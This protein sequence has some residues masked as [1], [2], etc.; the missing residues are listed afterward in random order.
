MSSSRTPKGLSATY[1]QT[2]TQSNHNFFSSSYRFISNLYP[3]LWVAAFIC[4]VGDLYK[5]WSRELDF[6]LHDLY[7]RS[8]ERGYSVV[9]TGPGWAWWPWPNQVI[10]VSGEATNLLQVADYGEP[11]FNS[12]KGVDPA[13]RKP[14]GDVIKHILGNKQSLFTMQGSAA[15]HERGLIK[16]HIGHD[17]LEKT[18]KYITDFFP[19]W[20]NLFKQREMTHSLQDE[21][22]YYTMQIIAR[23]AWGLGDIDIS[24]APIFRRMGD[25]IATGDASSPAF[26]KACQDVAALN[27]QHLLTHADDILSAKGYAFD[28][29][30]HEIRSAT[31]LTEKVIDE[32]VNTHAASGLVVADNLSRT[33]MFA[34]AIISEHDGWIARLNDELTKNPD[35]ANDW[36]ALNKAKWLHRLYLETLRFVSPT[37][38][39]VRL[40]SKPASFEFK[41]HQGKIRH[42]TAPPG[43]LLFVPLRSINHDSDTWP[44]PNRFNPE[45]FTGDESGF[46][47]RN[48]VP[49]SLGK[50]S[51]PGGAFFA[52]LVFKLT[53][54]K[55]FSEGNKLKL[56]KP[57]EEIS[58]NAISTKWKQ[59][60]FA[61]I[62]PQ[63]PRQSI[64]LQ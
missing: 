30:P 53:I 27:K 6:I 13:A 16:S 55:F 9:Q 19:V 20:L 31:S 12:G 35:W 62:Q 45:R 38:A 17:S 21:V 54:A 44:D 28:Q 63:Q 56:D 37:T 52:P 33:I 40:T 8:K 46:Q 15:T 41:D 23:C 1:S 2:Y 29:L 61:T 59:D 32:I 51:C 7:A 10:V 5:L 11:D 34:L 4:A 57:L 39:D 48:F 26:K 43:T 22:L 64:N 60:Y 42:H 36:N 3:I 14:V 50:R 49:F 58:R 47:G 18:R 24:Y 25:Y